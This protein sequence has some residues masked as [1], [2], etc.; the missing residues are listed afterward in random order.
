MADPIKPRLSNNTRA[1]FTDS[2]RE[3][4]AGYELAVRP[5]SARTG[6]DS[7]YKLSSKESLR[8]YPEFCV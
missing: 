2:Q 4:D 7:I 8:A 6:L 1:R 5:S 3:E